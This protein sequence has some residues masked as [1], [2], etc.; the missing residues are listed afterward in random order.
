M[1]EFTKRIGELVYFEDYDEDYI[2]YDVILSE[3]VSRVYK[4]EKKVKSIERKLNML[5]KMLMNS[6]E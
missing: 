6:N 4:L 2:D 3:L 5:I 1:E